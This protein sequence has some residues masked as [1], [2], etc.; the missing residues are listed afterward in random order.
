M[1]VKKSIV[2]QGEV[3]DKYADL[4]EGIL[5]QDY[6]LAEYCLI[7]TYYGVKALIVELLPL[8]QLSSA[9]RIV[10]VTSNYGE[11]H[12][13]QNTKHTYFPYQQ[14]LIFDFFEWY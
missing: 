3:A 14:K 9:A 1:I 13:S 11:L 8:L 12:V 10:K 5:V 6:K 4:L 2:N 7:T